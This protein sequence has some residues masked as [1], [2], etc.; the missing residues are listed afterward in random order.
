MVFNQCIIHALSSCSFSKLSSLDISLSKAWKQSLA[1]SPVL[2]EHS[3]Y[4]IP[5]ESA[6]ACASYVYENEVSLVQKGQVE[7]IGRINVHEIHALMSI[8]LRG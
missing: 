8:M 1:F 4:G 7:E 2:L 6:R 5:H 3:M